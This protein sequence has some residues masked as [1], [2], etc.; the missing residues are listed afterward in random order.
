MRRLATLGLSAA[1][2]MVALPGTSVG[3]KGAEPKCHGFVATKV[4]TD[5]SQVIRGTD[6]R[7]VIL[8]KGGADR[9]FTGDGND[10]VCAGPGNDVVEGGDGKD[11]LFGSGGNDTLRGGPAHDRLV[12]EGGRDGCYPAAGNDTL[13][14]CEGADLVVSI[15][16]PVTVA[17]GQAIDFRI[18][19]TNAGST[20]SAPYELVIAATPTSVACSSDPSGT[21]GFPSVWPRA[22]AETDHT[23]A[24]GCVTQSASDPNLTIT[25]RLVMDD[26][27]ADRSNDQSSARIALQSAPTAAPSILP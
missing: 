23:I 3:A 15:D 19:V 16:A 4:G 18:R 10:I 20:R 2:L 17:D 14:D 7:D 24:G 12:G 21:T 9:I 27:D 6:H 26:R 1:L 13:I 11:R 25:A 5:R 22:F 8:A